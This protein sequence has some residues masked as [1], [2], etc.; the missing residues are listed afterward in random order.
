MLAEALAA[1]ASG[2]SERDFRQSLFLSQCISGWLVHGAL[3]EFESGRTV[4]SGFSGTLGAHTKNWK[5]AVF[6]GGLLPASGLEA[7]EV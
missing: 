2:E 5:K 3:L 6:P 4:L 1:L 7:C